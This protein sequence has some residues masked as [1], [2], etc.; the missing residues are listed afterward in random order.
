MEN[1]QKN[2]RNSFNN[3]IFTYKSHSHKS[4]DSIL[5]KMPRKKENNSPKVV[6]LEMKAFPIRL[7][8]Y[9]EKY[10]CNHSSKCLLLQRTTA[11]NMCHVTHWKSGLASQWVSGKISGGRHLDFKNNKIIVLKGNV[12]NSSERRCILPKFNT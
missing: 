2:E 10:K 3:K 8:G 5:L 12:S 11:G 1:E 7:F 9:I 4:W 6:C